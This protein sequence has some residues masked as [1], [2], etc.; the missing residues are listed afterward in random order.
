M[1]GLTFEQMAE[2]YNHIQRRL[3][4]TFKFRLPNLD[5]ELDVRDY[6]L[7][8]AC[9]SYFLVRKEDPDP[10]PQLTVNSMG[11]LDCG[12]PTF[13]PAHFIWLHGCTPELA[14][15]IREAVST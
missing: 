15:Q 7:K 5:Q 6:R 14:Q 2:T 9:G 3:E 10:N 11:Y 1:N 4:P 13:H 8:E 12:L